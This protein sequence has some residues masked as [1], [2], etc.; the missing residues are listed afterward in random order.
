LKTV[1]FEAI[2]AASRSI[3]VP[4]DVAAQLR[5]GSNVRVIVMWETPEE[6]D[7]AWR[8]LTSERFALGYAL[9]DSIFDQLID[10][11]LPESAI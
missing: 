6:E 7:E 8:T 4:P 3:E 10:V 11:S 2:L 1:E 9:E 5:A